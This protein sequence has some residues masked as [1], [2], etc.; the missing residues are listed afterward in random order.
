MLKPGF[1]LRA[2]HTNLHKPYLLCT[3]GACLCELSWIWAQVTETRVVDTGQNDS[4]ALHAVTE[5]AVGPSLHRG[6][7]W[8]C[9]TRLQVQFRSQTWCCRT[10]SSAS[11]LQ[12][13][14]PRSGRQSK[15]ETLGAEFPDTWKGW[16]ESQ[17]SRGAEC[18]FITLTSLLVVMA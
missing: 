2:L 16:T 1:E 8:R 14:P 15:E 3:P 6:P 13:Q 10:Q 9:K 5:I 18:L 4:M 7:C 12:H 17:I 11:S